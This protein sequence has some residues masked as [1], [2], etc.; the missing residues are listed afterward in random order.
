MPL[1]KCPNCKE[2]ISDKSEKCIHCGTELKKKLAEFCEDCGASIKK[3]ET[4]C[5][6]C[7]CPVKQEI[8]I[9]ESKQKKEA[10]KE[11]KVE[12]K[13][14]ENKNLS[15]EETINIEPI[16]VQK[17]KKEISLPVQNNM[18]VT[19]AKQKKSNSKVVL[20]CIVSLVIIALVGVGIYFFLPKGTKTYRIAK[21]IA[22]NDFFDPTLVEKTPTN[23]KY[24]FVESVSI[25]T[26]DAKKSDGERA[27][28]SLSK[29]NTHIEAE[30]RKQ[31]IEN[32]HKA[33]EE[34]STGTILSES[35][36]IQQLIESKEDLL[37][38][39]NNYLIR[40]NRYYQNSYNSLKSKITS[41]LYTYDLKDGSESDSEST[42]K[43][44]YDNK[45]EEAKKEFEKEKISFVNDAIEEIEKIIDKLDNCK[46]NYCDEFIKSIDQ[47]KNYPETK[48]A[49][50]KA[51]TKYD[52]E[53][54]KKKAVV[55]SINSKLSKVEKSLN[56]NE[57][58]A[59]IDEIG[60]L[61]DSFYSSYIEQWNKR[62]D[63]INT[64]VYKK[65]CKTINYKDALRYPDKYEGQSTY[66]IG[67]IVQKVGENE[68]RVST[69]CEWFY[70]TR[71]CNDNVI[72]VYYTGEE[73]FIEDDY[74]KI[75]GEM[76]GNYSYKA[77]LGNEITIPL[78][79]AKYM[80]R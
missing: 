19:S 51:K 16:K 27:A 60:Q 32:W 7:G 24:S 25:V 61:D 54:N 8:V 20:I 72:Y 34:Y 4:V 46:G 49:Y 15:T 14:V 37:F 11:I 65:S 63:N 10:N 62:L 68:F 66:W 79:R 50:N 31:Y 58:D 59:I 33:L 76:A 40:I 80:K 23:E 28:V 64:N 53:I 17:N 3:G 5:S 9:K 52:E 18:T 12:E 69:K 47:Y 21:E 39:Y 13:T 56:K 30:Q 41:I 48:E 55:N 77:V 29:Y 78:V 70:G 44:Y 35:S 74:V 42:I 43:A 26:P 36:R 75:W 6:K 38:T 73:S 57:Y 67:E 71:Y 1:I 22:E 45:L 2:E